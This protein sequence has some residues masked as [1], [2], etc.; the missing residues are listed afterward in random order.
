[1]MVDVRIDVMRSFVDR[2]RRRESFLQIVAVGKGGPIFT[3]N[4]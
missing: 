4:M 1:M 3:V 2:C